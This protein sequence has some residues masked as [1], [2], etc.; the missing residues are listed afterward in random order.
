MEQ[1]LPLSPGQLLARGTS[2]HLASHDFACLEEFSPAKGLRV[3]IMAL[4]PKGALWIVECKSSRADFQ[5]DFKWQG[6]LDY[7]D[8]YFWAVDRDFPTELLPDDTGLI[9]ADGYGAEILRM[10]HEAP[11]NT[12]R[13]KSLVQKFARNAAQRLQY[14]RDPMGATF[15]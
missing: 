7:C 3:D 13:R 14:M 1:T 11:L 4:G 15:L 12:A 5:S 2:R 6:Y 9:I 8:R 10:G